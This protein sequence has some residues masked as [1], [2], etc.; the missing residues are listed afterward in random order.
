M[1]FSFC[2]FDAFSGKILKVFDIFLKQ[3]IDV[4]YR[5]DHIDH[6][7][8]IVRKS[9]KFLFPSQCTYKSVNPSCIFWTQLSLLAGKWNKTAGYHRHVLRL[10][11]FVKKAFKKMKT[12]FSRKNTFF[13]FSNFSNFQ[14]FPTFCQKNIINKAEEIFKNNTIWYAFWSKFATF[15]DLEIIQDFFPKKPIYF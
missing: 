3:Q 8:V 5:K 10:A 6:Q 12:F 4:G 14:N 2:F 9:K 11:I 13:I 1:L 15:S 7:S